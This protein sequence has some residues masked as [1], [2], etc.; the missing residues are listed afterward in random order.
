MSL[1]EISFVDLGLVMTAVLALSF[2]GLALSGHFPA[3]HR[4]PALR[5]SIGRLVVDGSMLMALAALA[6][7]IWFGLRSVAWPYLVLGGG[8]MA[9]SAPLILPRF[10]DPFIDGRGGLV[11]FASSAALAALGMLLR[12]TG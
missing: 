12:T 6:I 7:T 11:T 2:Y 8:T 5:G 10:S 1:A 9:L 4:A 3:E